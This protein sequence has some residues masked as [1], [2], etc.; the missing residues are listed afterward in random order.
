MEETMKQGVASISVTKALRI[1]GSIGFVLGTG[2]V[3]CSLLLYIQQNE[4]SVFVTYL[5]DIGNKPGWPQV[6]FNSGML[7]SSPIRYLFL[8]L[9]ILQ[10]SYF[11]ASR[12]FATAALV[13][14]GFVVIGSIGVSA[15]PFSLNLKLHKTSAL[16][17]FFGVVVLQ[18]MIALQEGRRKLP[19]ILPISSIAV[20]AVYLIFAVLLSLVGK[21]EAITRDTPVIWEWLA[22]CSLMFWLIVHTVLLGSVKIVNHCGPTTAST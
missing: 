5:S 21:V 15:I 22:F 4:F 9:L 8:V 2:T 14:G 18:T 16:I 11:G 6:V 12:A 17:Y 19:L 7:I 20:V 1:L 10:L 3:L 13:I